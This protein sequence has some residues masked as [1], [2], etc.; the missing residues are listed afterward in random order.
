ML[1]GRPGNQPAIE[2]AWPGCTR[3][4][5]SFVIL[6]KKN[7]RK[8][9]TI[10]VEA[11]DAKLRLPILLLLMLPLRLHPQAPG[12]PIYFDPKQ[13]I[14]LRVDDLMGQLNLPCVYVDQLGK[15]IPEKMDACKRF[16]AGTYT[17]EIG[18]GSVVC[19][20]SSEEQDVA[21][22]NE[23]SK[24]PAPFFLVTRFREL[25]SRLDSKVCFDGHVSWHR[26]FANALSV[27]NAALDT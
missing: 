25:Q 13:P 1:H 21:C 17:D 11:F 5:E 9:R 22:E 20:L 3:C 23:G 8:E 10:P 7:S 16:A 27:Q 14:E 6:P 2:P 24:V 19:T 18:P 15:S 26:V 4:W 12:I